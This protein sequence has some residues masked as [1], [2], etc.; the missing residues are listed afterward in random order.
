MTDFNSPSMSMVGKSFLLGIFV[1]HSSH[2]DTTQVQQ[3]TPS[4]RDVNAPLDWAAT[5]LAAWDKSSFYG[6]FATETGHSTTPFSSSDTK[7]L[8][9]PESYQTANTAGF[10]TP[11]HPYRHPWN[12]DPQSGNSFVYPSVGVPFGVVHDWPS[13]PGHGECDLLQYAL[14]PNVQQ[15]QGYP[16]HPQWALGTLYTQTCVLPPSHE[17]SGVSRPP[18]SEAASRNSDR[19]ADYATEHVCQR[20]RANHKTGSTPY[21]RGPQKSASLPTSNRRSSHAHTAVDAEIGGAGPPGHQA[22]WTLNEELYN[23]LFAVLYPKQRPNRKA[24]PAPSGR[25]KMCPTV[26]GRTG[27]L[28]QHV[29]VI[30]RQRIARKFNNTKTHCRELAFAFLVAHLEA[31]PCVIDGALRQESERYLCRLRT[32]PPSGLV[33]TDSDEFPLLER[34]LSDVIRWSD[35]L[36]VKCERCNLWLTKTSGLREH[37]YSCAS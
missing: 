17:Q 10:P 28:Q 35:W 24:E 6:P 30:H 4:M 20:P 36:G 25:C 31:S 29:Q 5:Y 12:D 3:F 7:T 27:S 2:Q 1:A 16:Y 32:C 19:A 37:R 9:A 34:E 22:G 13:V 11:S 8:S 23:W 33:L 21:A 15:Q 26:C 14:A 18:A